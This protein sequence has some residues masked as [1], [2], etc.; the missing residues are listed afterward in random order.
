MVVAVAAAVVVVG[1]Y[2]FVFHYSSVVVVVEDEF[3]VMDD[4]VDCLSSMAMASKH[5]RLFDVEFRVSAF[6]IE[7]EVIEHY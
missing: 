1:Q 6:V 2:F 3:V 4:V 5:R 7:F